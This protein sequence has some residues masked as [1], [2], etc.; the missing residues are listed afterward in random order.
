[1]VQYL[2]TFGETPTER[3]EVLVAYDSDFVYLAARLYDSDPAGILPGAFQRDRLGLANDW[4]GLSLDT[5]NDNENMLLFATSPSGIRTDVAFSNDTEGPFPLNSSWNTFWDVAT[6]RTEDGWFAE[7][8]I[9]FS[10]LRFQ[11]DGGEV[12]MGMTVWRWIAR[13][14]EA[15][16]FPAIPPRWRWAHYKPSQARD[17]TFRGVQRKKPVHVSPYAL[18]G[19]Q[20]GK[21]GVIDSDGTPAFRDFR[22]PVTEAG[23][24]LKYGVTDNLT[25]D[26]TINT[27][28]AQVEADD[29]R[30][31]F[32]RFSLFFPEKRLF[33]QERAS[34]FEFNTGGPDRVFHSR[35]I[36]LANGL[37]VRIYG[38][39]RLVGR[40]GGFTGCAGISSTRTPTPAASSRAGSIPTGT[41]TPPWDW[42]RCSVSPAT[43]T[44]Q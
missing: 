18:L 11:D 5:F 17:V 41:T 9:P 36:G 19:M 34:A 10:S 39:A 28:F 23:L 35:R 16:L 26:L 32:N 21:L 31:N 42:T 27:D 38:G 40:T 37:P 13:K 29:Q 22:E 12:V 8:R 24:D 43:T 15:S 3:S 33:F 30:V 6:S 4:I 14:Q 25:F 1:M 44:W 20:E 7:L 2:P